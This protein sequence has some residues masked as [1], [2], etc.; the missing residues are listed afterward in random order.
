MK[1]QFMEFIFPGLFSAT[2]FY[3]WAKILRT[4][5]NFL[6]PMNQKHEQ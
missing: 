6:A 3:I 5:K 1:M 4:P 2:F